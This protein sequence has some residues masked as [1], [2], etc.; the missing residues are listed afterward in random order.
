MRRRRRRR[1]RRGRMMVVVMI[2][3]WACRQQLALHSYHAHVGC[4]PAAGRLGGWLAWLA[5]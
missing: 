2:I 1:R 4:L 3:L 5:L